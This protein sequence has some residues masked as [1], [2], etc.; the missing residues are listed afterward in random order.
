MRNTARFH[1]V[2]RFAFLALFL[3]TGIA[4]GLRNELPETFEAEVDGL[5]DLERN[6]RSF[7]SYDAYGPIR[8]SNIQ[9]HIPD[10]NDENVCV[11]ACAHGGT[12]VNK[13][14][15]CPA[16]WTGIDCTQGGL[17]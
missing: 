4:D 2:T 15:V 5:A 11:P 12:C 7:R 3:T 8:R 16:G 13:T 1:P 17:E 10:Q 14:C 9:R 6:Q